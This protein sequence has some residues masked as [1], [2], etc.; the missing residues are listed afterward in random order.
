M[1]CERGWPS[2]LR[3]PRLKPAG[4]F[5]FFLPLLHI[6]SWSLFYFDPPEIR[7]TTSTGSSLNCNVDQADLLFTF[8]PCSSAQNA[9]LLL[10][11]TACLT[12]LAGWVKAT[13]QTR[14]IAWK[15]SNLLNLVSAKYLER[16]LRQHTY[17]DPIHLSPF[18]SA[19]YGHI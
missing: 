10:H 5:F 18:L 8:S 7:L 12:C 6:L 1:T 14:D 2:R 17:A 15:S 11:L 3:P 19:N 4:Y 13:D 16:V 9:W